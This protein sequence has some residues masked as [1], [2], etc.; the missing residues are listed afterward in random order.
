MLPHD[1]E[2][3]ET[4]KRLIPSFIRFQ[5]YD[6][7]AFGEGQPLYEVAPL[8]IS[9]SECG[10]A[11]SNGKIGLVRSRYIVATCKRTCEDIEAT[12]NGVDVS[13]R[14]DVEA[15]RERLFLDSYYRI[16]SSWRWH[17]FNTHIHVVAQPSFEPFGE[18]WELGYGP[19]NACLSV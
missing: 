19:I 18:G 3:M 8:V 11:T 12:S 7:T 4:P 10:F 16:V 1:V 9:S 2:L 5:R 6:D 17:V 13:P 14:L 15:Q